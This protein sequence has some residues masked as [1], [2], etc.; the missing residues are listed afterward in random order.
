[1]PVLSATRVGRNYRT[2]VPR[3]VRKLL[4]LG[5]GDAIEWVFEDGRVVVR[6]KADT[7]K[8]PF[9]GHEAGASEF[10]LLRGPWRYRMHDVRRLVCPRCGGVFNHYRGVTSR[11]KV[12]EFTVKVRPRA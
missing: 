8:C 11:G 3:E 10:K 9:C 4:G 6:K 12:V 7:V 5:R 2:T 1:M